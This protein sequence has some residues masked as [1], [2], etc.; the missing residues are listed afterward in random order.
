MEEA[1]VM[2][3][4]ELNTE[5]QVYHAFRSLKLYAKTKQQERALLEHASG[6]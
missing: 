3:T 5:K 4:I 6:F 1:L 2:N